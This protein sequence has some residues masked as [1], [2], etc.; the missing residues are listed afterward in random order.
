M[1]L[2]ITMLLLLVLLVMFLCLFTDL[3]QA[4]VTTIAVVTATAN[5]YGA[6]I[7]IASEKY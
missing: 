7:D 5:A 3:V 4:F 6:V 2:A 1:H